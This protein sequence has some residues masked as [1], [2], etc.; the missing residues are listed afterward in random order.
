MSEPTLTDIINE[1]LNE[2]DS[3]V[4]DTPDEGQED[5]A[6]EAVDEV[7]ADEAETADEPEAEESDESEDEEV[8]EGEDADEDVEAETD[9]FVVKVDGE[10]LSVTLE[11]LKAGY[12]RQAH[13]TRSMQALKEE[14]ETFEAEAAQHVETIQQIA[15]LDAAWEA[16]PVSVLTSL[17]ASTENPSYALGLLV[18]EAAANDLLTED[19]LQY[20]GIDAATKQAWSTETELERLRRE[21]KERSEREAQLQAKEQ[22]SASEA[23]VREAVQVF[24][25]QINEI[26]AE[27]G[28]D[29]PTV[30]EKAAFKADLLRYAKDNSILDLKK[31]YAALAYERDRESRATAA[32]R[33]KSH[34]KKAAT[35]VVSRSGASAAG[36]SPV[37]NQSQDLR[38]VIEQTMKDLKF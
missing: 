1:T 38:S 32:R 18:K 33:A 26:V 14:R 23:R 2:L 5:A 30:Q 31:A 21:V 6:V 36:V 35:K 7:E 37:A 29:F 13:F 19:A 20:F 28:L 15:D 9:T 25:N 3:E 22:E 10:E 27:E 11:E 16:N 8:E 4:T 24:E 12:S 17:L 34:Q